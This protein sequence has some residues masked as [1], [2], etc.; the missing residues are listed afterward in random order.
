LI[1]CKECVNAIVVSSSSHCHRFI[2]I[3]GNVRNVGVLQRKNV[4]EETLSNANE[5]ES[6][7]TKGVEKILRRIVLK[8]LLGLISIRNLCVIV[9]RNGQKKIPTVSASY[10]EKPMVGAEPVS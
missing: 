3:I 4:L 6:G 10:G 5:I 1:N 8:H 2:R 7:K 9:Q